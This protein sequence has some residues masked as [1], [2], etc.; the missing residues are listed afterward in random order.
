MDSASAQLGFDT[1]RSPAA[2]C[3]VAAW[4]ARREPV[5]AIPDLRRQPGPMPGEPLPVSFLK[6][7]DEQT[8]I[9]LAA[10]CH[11]AVGHWNEN[12]RAWGV[13]GAP[14]YMGRFAMAPALLRY[15]EEGCWGVSPHMIP[16]RSLHALSGTVSQALKIHGPN[17]GTG[18]GP[19]GE[20]E[21]LLTALA[22]LHG[23]HLPGVWV[24]FTRVDPELAPDDTGRPPPGS[25]LDGL[26]LALKRP[27]AEN[28]PGDGGVRLTLR[29]GSADSAGPAT[30]LSAG[31]FN[32]AVLREWLL[33]I[34]SGESLVGGPLAAGVQI[35]LARPA[36]SS[37][38][39]EGGRMKDE[40]SKTA[41]SSFIHHP[42]SFPRSA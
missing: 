37:A 28:G 34:E 42:S 10:V 36:A 12:L 5:E 38:K 6:H 41:V 2:G 29:I 17:F 3:I 35:E 1:P 33:R 39:D 14:R 32:L 18:G 40:I 22:L 15:R 11:A 24:V 7:A 4:A 13:L 25:H 16:H 21:A 31:A 26:A 19:G 30:P 23:K 8:V 27:L 9:G 20:G